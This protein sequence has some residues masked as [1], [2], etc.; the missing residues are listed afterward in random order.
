MTSAIDS[1]V[2]YTLILEQFASPDSSQFEFRLT[3]KPNPIFNGIT[4]VVHHTKIIRQDSVELEISV[5]V[6]DKINIFN[7]IFVFREET[8]TL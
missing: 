7:I 3:V 1:A 4:N 6:L 2:T 5:R 8:L